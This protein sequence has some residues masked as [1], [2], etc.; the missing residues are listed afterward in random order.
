MPRQFAWQ[1]DTLMT[2]LLGTFRLLAGYGGVLTNGRE[3]HPVPLHEQG[4]PCGRHQ[5]QDRRHTQALRSNPQQRRRS[6]L[7]LQRAF[8]EER[9]VYVEISPLAPD[10]TLHYTDAVGGPYASRCRYPVPRT[11]AIRKGSSGHRSGS[12]GTDATQVGVHRFERRRD[13]DPG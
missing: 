5:K 9:Q 2:L 7:Y 1:G 8:H 6:R 11:T 10:E 13:R 4:H 12:Q 3:P